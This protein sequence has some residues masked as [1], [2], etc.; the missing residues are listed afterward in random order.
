[1]PTRQS[2][3][4]CQPIYDRDQN[5]YGTELLFR[6]DS[7]SSAT[8][9]GEDLATSQV[10]LNLCTDVTRQLESRNRILFINISPDLLMADGFLPLPAEHV[11]LELPAST[12][13]SIDLLE[14]IRHWKKAGFRFSLDDFDFSTKQQGLLRH[15]DYV[16]IDALDH[17]LVQHYAE[18]A[19]L[20]SPHLTVIAKRVETKEQYAALADSGFKLFQ[21]YFLARP[22]VVKGQALRGKIS[23]SVATFNAA[24]LEEI[25]IEDMVQIVNRDPSLAT[26]LLKIVNSPACN[27]MRPM[28][29]IRD[30]VVFLGLVQV[31]KWIIM[32][33]ML[34]ESAAGVGSMDL[35]LTRAKACENYAA[36][37][38]SIRSDQAFLI[39]LLS[40]VNLLFGIK[41]NEFLEM[42]PLHPEIAAAVLEQDGQLGRVLAKIRDIE[43]QVL[44]K[45]EKVSSQEE[46]LLTS[47]LSASRWASEVLTA[48]AA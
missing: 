8:A 44:Q 43:Q 4:A 7:F 13:F 22:Q 29:S 15:F 3:L 24:S 26:Q 27:L 12:P 1:M 48:K 2:L 14:R 36:V 5:I 18:I 11:V 9:F 41:V 25:E 37:A 42:L 35:V 33:S 19:R 23:H 32:M 28:K 20:S 45:E 46:E 38:L 21:G 30:A 40:G 16:K 31:R 34:N 17:G 47:Y 6:H 39:G 10:I